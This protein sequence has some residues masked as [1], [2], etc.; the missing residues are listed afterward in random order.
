MKIYHTSIPKV[1]KYH[2]ERIIVR[3][4]LWKP[5]R[6]GNLTRWLEFAD[7]VYEW[8]EHLKP[9]PYD[10]LVPNLERYEWKL[11]ENGWVNPKK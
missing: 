2:G 5:K 7:M 3:R 4:F 10:F 1:G 9:Y 6:Y 11:I 8:Q